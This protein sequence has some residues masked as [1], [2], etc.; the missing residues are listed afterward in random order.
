ML[1]WL[2]KNN[3]THCPLCHEDN[4]NREWGFNANKPSITIEVICQ[5]CGLGA[6]FEYGLDEEKEEKEG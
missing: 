1:R 3:Y 4:L 6:T 5:T 2:T